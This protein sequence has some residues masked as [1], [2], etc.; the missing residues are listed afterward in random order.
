MI[1]KRHTWAAVLLSL[2]TPGLGHL[3][4]G[5]A[6]AAL[7]FGIL[8]GP[9]AV[10]LFLLA[11]FTAPSPTVF[12]LL[13]L[14]VLSAVWAGV[15]I[16]AARHARRAGST[17]ELRSFNRWFVYV[18][19]VLGVAL[20]QQALFFLSKTYVAEAFRMPSASGEPTLLIGDFFYILKFPRT[21]R[22]ELTDA[23]V[24]SRTPEQRGLRVVK[25]AVGLPG[26]T[27][28]MRDGLLYR[29]GRPITE[30]YTKRHNVPLPPE[31]RY[32]SQMRAWQI[33]HLVGADPARYRPTTRDWGPLVVPPDSFFAIG[34][35][36]DESY[37]SRFYGFIPLATI[38]GQPSLI[39][40]SYQSGV[41][42][43]WRRLGHRIS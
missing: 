43:R 6:P 40:F 18:A 23:L 32:V 8:T 39:Y 31:D 26:D 33:P 16:H 24:V 5:S 7:L 4:A 2:L 29:N 41:G 42:V 22:S 17:Y 28:R 3:Y 34:D 10:S 9:I 11:V 15:P 21:V 30:P 36:R 38:S 13:A 35:N 1:A 19:F 14:T 37:D 25:R 12:L 27:L 20:W